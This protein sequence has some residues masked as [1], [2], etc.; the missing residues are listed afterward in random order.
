MGAGVEGQF[1]LQLLRLAHLGLQSDAHLNVLLPLESDPCAG[2]F[3][4]LDNSAQLVLGLESIEVLRE[5]FVG[6]LAHRRAGLEVN[7]RNVGHRNPLAAAF[8]HLRAFASREVVV[9]AWLGRESLIGLIHFRLLQGKQPAGL[10][11]LDRVERVA[12]AV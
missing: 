9:D 12:L 5:G 3:D 6:L 11:R 8:V 4:L 1:V 2:R 7:G 10:A